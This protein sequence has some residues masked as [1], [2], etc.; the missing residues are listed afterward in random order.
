MPSLNGTVVSFYLGGGRKH[1]EGPIEICPERALQGV[2]LSLQCLHHNNTP[3]SLP[4]TYHISH[5]YPFLL[6]L[7]PVCRL[8]VN[9]S[10]YLLFTYLS[11]HSF[12]LTYFSFYHGYRLYI[13]LF[14]IFR[15]LYI[16]SFTY[17][18][19]RLRTIKYIVDSR[20]F[21]LRYL[22]SIVSIV[23]RFNN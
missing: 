16:L 14:Q 15:S 23:E 22:L 8:R 5:A 3:S 12:P 2:R 1:G 20:R 4:F 21:C 6:P 13:T 7:F 10:Y 17:R 19:L 11:F 9:L 18:M